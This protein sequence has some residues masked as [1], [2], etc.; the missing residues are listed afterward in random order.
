ML[1]PGTC[2]QPGCD[3]AVPHGGACPVHPRRARRAPDRRELDATQRGYDYKWKR[4]AANFLRAHPDCVDCGGRAEVP[5]HWPLSRRELVAAGDP[6]PDAW[7]HLVPRCTSDHNA[8]SARD[9]S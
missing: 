5:D 2:P 1:A 3:E 9:R 7:H 4:N 8:R 6:H